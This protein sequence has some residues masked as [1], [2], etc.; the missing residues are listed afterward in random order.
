M[1]QKL[2]PFYK[3]AIRTSLVA[4]DRI[5]KNWFHVFTVIELQTPDAYPYS[6]PNEQWTKNCVRSSQSKLCDYTFYLS[7]DEI[8]SVEDAIELFNNPLENFKIDQN[9]INFINTSFTKEPSGEVPL[10]F[11][12]NF[13][14][15]NG[16]AAILPKSKSGL[17]VWS[18]IDINRS[19]EAT[20]T[21]NV[22]ARQIEAIRDL[23]NTWLGFDL[24]QKKEH[25][26]NIYLSTPN[27]YFRKIDVSLS[28][29][30][31]GIFYKIFKR[32]EITNKLYFRLIDK[33]GD[34]IALDRTVEIKEPV[35][36]IELPHEPH[37]FELRVYNDEQ[38]LIAVHEPY[39]FLKAIHFGLSMKQADLII[40]GDTNNGEK[41][42]VVEKFSKESP[43][44]IG[45]VKKIN[46]EYYFKDADEDRLHLELEKNREFIF[47]PGSKDPSEKSRLKE[48]AKDVIR[49]IL[50]RAKDTCYICDPYFSS[51]DMIE[52][53]FQIRNSGVQINIINSKE[54]IK[55]VEAQRMVALLDEYNSKPFSKIS[56]KILS[57]NS[58]LHDRFI[59][60]DKNIWFLGSS[61][62]EFGSRATCIAKI[63]QSS[64]KLI[65][66][67]VEKWFMDESFTE[68]ISDYA[69]RTDH[70]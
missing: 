50:N 38:Q 70:G 66:K 11:P 16:I 40:K 29:N 34:A 51:M 15:Q 19:T 39:T 21:E 44:T 3:K 49:E 24:V 20:F 31:V 25:I 8:S 64:G 41:D 57:N 4:Q 7:V 28:T 36:L 47:F 55:K 67:E 43:T 13:Y 58:I 56:I 33:H 65:I 14:T 42:I 22:T 18:Q 1:I 63:P 12:P 69:K 59:I 10:V 30:P 35:G 17:L 23:T 6:I 48:K 46:P 53:A 9:K 26:G 54:A 61:F 5:K 27:P 52:F 45:E 37:L 68:N 32:T 2:K 62:N 60:T